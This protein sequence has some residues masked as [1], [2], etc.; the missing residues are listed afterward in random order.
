MKVKNNLQKVDKRRRY[1]NMYSLN[2]IA[3]VSI[4]ELELEI[5]L[6]RKRSRKAGAAGW[7]WRRRSTKKAGKKKRKW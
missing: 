4:F 3:R 5:E 6:D 1:K 7:G 2:V